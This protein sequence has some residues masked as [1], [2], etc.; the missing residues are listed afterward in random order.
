MVQSFAGSMAYTQYGLPLRWIT[1]LVSWRRGEP[2]DTSRDHDMTDWE[3]VDLFAERWQKRCR[4]PQKWIG[5]RICCS[6]P[7]NLL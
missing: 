4:R 6:R 3:A 2:T 1:K 5:S 7:A